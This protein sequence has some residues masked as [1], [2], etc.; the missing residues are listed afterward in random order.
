MQQ[1]TFNSW[2][3]KLNHRVE[4][5]ISVSVRDLPDMPYRTWFEQG[6]TAED[7][8]LTV[9]EKA[10]AEYGFA[11]EDIFEPAELSRD[12]LNRQDE[13]D[14]AIHSLLVTLTGKDIPWNIEDISTVRDAVLPIVS[15]HTGKT[16]LELY[17]A[18]TL[19][20]KEEVL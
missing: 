16:I 15:R 14:N 13:V 8:A 11:P 9:V 19:K 18:L 12:E 20:G 3:G 5:L 4:A 7:A 6:V 17:P 1:Q 2:F 10:L